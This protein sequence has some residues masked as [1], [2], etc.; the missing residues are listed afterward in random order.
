MK[1]L[2]KAPAFFLLSILLLTSCEKDNEPEPTILEGKWIS[3]EQKSVYYDEGGN[4]LYEVSNNDPVIKLEYNRNKMIEQ[5]GTSSSVTSTFSITQENGK[6]YITYTPD[7]AQGFPGAKM[8]LIEVTD[9]QLILQ[10]VTPFGLY[11]ENGEA[12]EADK[13]VKTIVYDKL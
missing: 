13:L 9:S 10:T 12:R 6:D 2:F 11:E 7:N 5:A 3:V 1:L 8:Q 4:V